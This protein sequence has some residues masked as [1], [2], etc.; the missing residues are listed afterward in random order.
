ML[1]ISL[2]IKPFS[3]KDSMIEFESSFLIWITKPDSSEKSCSFILSIPDK[4]NLIPTFFVKHISSNDVISPP[5]EISW[6]DSIVWLEIISWMHVNIDLKSS[7]LSIS[8][9]SLYLDSVTSEKIEPAILFLSF[10][11]IKNRAVSSSILSSGV[12]QTLT[13][14]TGAIAVTTPDKGLVTWSSLPSSDHL[15]FID[16]ESLPTGIETAK[17]M[18]IFDN[19]S[20]PS[21]RA[22]SSSFSPEAAIQLAE[23]W[24]LFNPLTTTPAILVK[25]SASAIRIEAAGL[26]SAN[27]GFSPIDKTS[28]EFEVKDLKLS[29]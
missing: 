17:S 14:S 7:T 5:S 15:V 10:N 23:T 22:K 29:E 9:V 11:L 18:L 4:S 6:M 24:T 1:A 28:P 12:A 27:V 21:L 2:I 3:C 19:A 26:E 13:S 20:T 16:N 25:A 8:G